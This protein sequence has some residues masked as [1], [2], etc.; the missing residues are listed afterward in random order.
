MGSVLVIKTETTKRRQEGR[1]R[2]NKKTKEKKKE[3]KKKRERA[4]ERKVSI[5][6]VRAGCLVPSAHGRFCNKE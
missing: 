4:R 2:R 3:E 1:R 6:I 5:F